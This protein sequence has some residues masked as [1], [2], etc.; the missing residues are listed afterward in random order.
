MEWR[1]I[2]ERVGEKSEGREEV[3]GGMEEKGRKGE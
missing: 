2:T 3:R 1:E